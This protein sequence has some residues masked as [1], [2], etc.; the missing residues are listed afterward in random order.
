MVPKVTRKLRSHRATAWEGLPLQNA[1]YGRVLA[2]LQSFF[3]SYFQLAAGHTINWADQLVYTLR[4][5]DRG[6]GLIIFFF[7]VG[8]GS[9]SLHLSNFP[10]GRPRLAPAR[11]P[12]PGAR[13]PVLLKSTMEA[14]GCGV[15]GSHLSQRARKM[16]H[17]SFLVVPAEGRGLLWESLASPRTSLSQDGGGL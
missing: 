4:G 6:S 9:A 2:R 14:V 13:R 10:I 17:P 1:N 16:G 8:R 15:F 12:I 5:A 7:I 3:W 11:T